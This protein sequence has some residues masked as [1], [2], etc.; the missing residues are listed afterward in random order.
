MNW[1]WVLLGAGIILLV[2]AASIY[3]QA[4]LPAPTGEFL[5]GRQ[6]ALFADDGRPEI[7]TADEN[8][9][10]QIAVQIWYPAQPDTG[11]ATGY[12]PNIGNLRDGLVRS[13]EVNPIEA[14]GLALI[15][16]RERLDAIPSSGH[17]PL[18]LFSPGN[19]TNAEFYAGLA[20]DLA[21]HGYVVVAL[22]HPFDVAAVA[23][24]N[25][26]LALFQEGPPA[27]R[28]QFTQQRVA[29]RA[30]DLIFALD[31][32][33]ALAAAGD[34]LSSAI[35]FNRV[36]VL[37]HSLGGLAAA[38]ACAE[39]NR[40]ITCGNLD[41]IQPGGIFAVSAPERGP[42]RPF[43]FMTK[44]TS[45]AGGLLAILQ[46][47]PA[48][49]TVVTIAEAS[50]ASFGDAPALVPSVLPFGSAADRILGLIRSE[51]RA[52]LDQTLMGSTFSMPSLDGA[53]IQNFGG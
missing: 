52:F 32:L 10:R 1:R 31:H 43:L 21:S 50:H 3:V 29:V 14:F 30:D 38:V 25:G 9:V 42:N 11:L 49:T 34:K 22:N 45:L 24:G 53:K 33:T 28:F 44:E 51:V 47:R 8:D 13:G 20:G 7:M 16:S 40:F 35:D 5:V 19:G 27:A 6:S 23:L 12:F 39:D 48:P 46:N 26:Q 17:F 2:A 37:G 4:E 36:A 41:G 15:R 18:V